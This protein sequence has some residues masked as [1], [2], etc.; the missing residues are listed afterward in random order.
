ML[1]AFLIALA[2]PVQPQVS[3]GVDVHVRVPAPA[4]HFEVEPALVVV[5]PGV[6][7]VHNYHR[8][9][10]FVNGYYWTHS[11]GT[12]FRTRSHRGAWT[13][14]PGHRVP[15]RVARIPRG[16]Y[17]YYKRGRPHARGHYR[18]RRNVRG[19]GGRGHSVVYK[20]RGGGG[21]RGHHRSHRKRRK[22]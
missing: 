4:V 20:H 8:E 6:M 22:H 12:W 10:F 19:H 9:V 3:V 15:V 1:T 14:V 7:V 13:A 11:G 2:V 17:K 16:K 5:S 21:G 18:H